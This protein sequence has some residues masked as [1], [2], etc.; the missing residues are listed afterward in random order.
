MLERVFDEVAGLQLSCKYCEIFK[1]IFFDK[2]TP[3]APSEKSINFPGKHRWRMRNR[4]IF[5]L[6]TTEQ[7][8]ML[9]SY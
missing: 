1:K 6:N 2:A 9:I 5:L 8:S 3:V 7:D 4:F